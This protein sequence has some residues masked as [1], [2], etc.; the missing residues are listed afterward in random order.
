MSK[1][2][3]LL[4]LHD[5]NEAIEA[6]DEYLTGLTAEQFYNDRKTKDAVI[7]NFE[8][9]GEASRQLSSGFKMLYPDIK[10]REMGDL[11]NKIIHEYFGIDYVVLW[12]ISTMELPSLWQQVRI[13]IHNFPQEK[14]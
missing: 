12:E 5:I 3:N 1:R 8:V 9:I 13:L 11:R 14:P 6:I 2:N 4:L 7:R 10:W